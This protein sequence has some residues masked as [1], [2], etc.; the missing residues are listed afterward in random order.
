MTIYY[1][2]P[3][4]TGSANGLT[5][6]DAF[7]TLQAAL[8]AATASGDEIRCI[9]N[10]QQAYTADVTFTINAPILSIVCW[11]FDTDTNVKDL[12][13][14][15]NLLR[16]TLNSNGGAYQTTWTYNTAV[17][18][19][20][21]HALVSGLHIPVGGS[22]IDHINLFTASSGCAIIWELCTFNLGT[23]GTGAQIKIAGSSEYEGAQI[24]NMCTFVTSHSLQSIA[25]GDHRISFDSCEFNVVAGSHLFDGQE[26]GPDLILTNCTIFGV[27]SSLLR[28]ISGTRRM[29]LV[30]CTFS[31][32]SLQI[33]AQLPNSASTSG[34]WDPTV[35]H[36]NTTI[37]DLTSWSEEAQSYNSAILNAVY[38]GVA[39]WES[40]VYK[41]S[42][43]NFV[44]TPPILVVAAT[45]N[46]HPDAY[47]TT[48]S[49]YPRLPAEGLNTFTAYLLYS[50]AKPLTLD[51]VRHAVTVPSIITL[52]VAP[53]DALLPPA[54]LAYRD[55]Y[56]GETV[57]FA[58]LDVD[59]GSAGYFGNIPLEVKLGAN[60]WLCPFF[61]SN[62]E[63]S[64]VP[65]TVRLGA[66]REDEPNTAGPSEPLPAYRA[67]MLVDGRIQEVTVSEPIPETAVPV[68]W[69]GT[70]LRSLLP[71][72]SVI[73]QN[74]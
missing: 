72:E 65:A 17:T 39:Y 58:K 50:L 46:A 60:F 69:D 48:I 64:D 4:A 40:L 7:L 10:G 27:R 14:P 34:D 63:T 51:C 43:Q 47:F 62:G 54:V 33:P 11:D 61:T 31:L 32:D 24:F 19:K 5:K 12:G 22:A 8:T 53:D 59:F 15:G 3:A 21:R 20:T 71:G 42:L 68:V 36:T 16:Y 13:Y 49:L 2:N 18:S 26:Q 28:A 9:A 55:T 6:A 74:P 35:T 37:L 67:L 23:T 1:V 56:F 73:L 66:L 70:V 44:P 57:A 29:H 30:D 52:V 38:G 41:E 45:G 25:V